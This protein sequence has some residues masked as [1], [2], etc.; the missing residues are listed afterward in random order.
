ML[1]Q[2]HIQLA[3]SY[4]TRLLKPSDRVVDATC[5]NGHDSL[6]LAQHLFADD[7][8]GSLWALDLQQQAIE[9][10]YKLLKSQLAPEAF[11]RVVFRCASHE[12]PP[13]EIALSSLAL[14][15]YNLGYL[16]G[17]DKQVKTK[18]EV[19]LISVE[20]FAHLL[21][22]GGV[23]SITCY[24][25]HDEGLEEEQLLLSW[26]EK[27]PKRSWSCLWHRSVNGYRAPSLLLIE[28]TNHT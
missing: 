15:V 11:D 27:L 24:P 19:T 8:S 14:V 2:N 1:L 3:R 16:P 18:G 25:G 6:F 21:Q 28:K 12:V 13:E 22:P 5:G 7:L 20:R 9:K 4:W 26:A 10:S 17:S 23:L